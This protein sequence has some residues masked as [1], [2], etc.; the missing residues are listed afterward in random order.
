[1]AEKKADKCA[2]SGCEC[3]VPKGSKYCSPYYEGVGNR[4]QVWTYGVSSRGAARTQ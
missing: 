4:L 1:M 2:H 3:G